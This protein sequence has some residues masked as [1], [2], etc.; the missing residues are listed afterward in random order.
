MTD[1]VLV[2]PPAALLSLPEVKAQL[3]VDHSHEDSWLEL[4]IAAAVGKLDGWHGIL[5]RCILTQTWAIKTD[6]L[7]DMRLPFPDVVSAVVTYLDPA[8]VSQTV[9]STNF[10]VR[11]FKGQ[12]SLIFSTGYAAPAVLAGR[13]DAVTVTGVYGFETPPPAL[14][15][16]ALMLV[17]YWER[18]REGAGEYIPPSI[19]S[20]ISPWRAGLAA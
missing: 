14:K 15:V 8:G 9:S 4:M 19:Y 11:T 17:A 12:G 7:A 2:T 13:D 1:P 5:H 6:A 18:N 10:R 20:L 3:K 16:A